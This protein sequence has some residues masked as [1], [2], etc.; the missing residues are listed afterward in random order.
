MNEEMV[1]EEIKNV[2]DDM[3]IEDVM[4]VEPVDSKNP[5]IGGVIVGGVIAAAGLGFLLYKK[6]KNKKNNDGSGKTN[7][8]FNIVEDD[9]EED[10]EDESQ[11][12]E[13]EKE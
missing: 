2:V 12:D 1:K 3:V 4:V 8:R 6:I 11:I 10:Y 9:Y 5:I 7:R 13:D